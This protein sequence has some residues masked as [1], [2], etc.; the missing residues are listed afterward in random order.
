MAITFFRSALRGPP[1]APLAGDVGA[2]SCRD[3]PNCI[4]AD[5]LWLPPKPEFVGVSGI[6]RRMR[7]GKTASL[8]DH[9]VGAGEQHGRHLDAERLRG[10]QVDDE[11][12]LGR[13]LDR[14]VAWLCSA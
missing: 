7:R 4:H 11:I 13:L 6:S 1:Q 3:C 2:G 12:E 14:D 5:Q 9:L 8:F 10:R